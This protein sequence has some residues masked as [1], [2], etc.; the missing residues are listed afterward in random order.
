[1]NTYKLMTT[2]L[3]DETVAYDV[4]RYL[5]SRQTIPTV[6]E[7]TKIKG[8]GEATANKVLACM[9]LSA[10]YMVGTSTTTFND[11]DDIARRFCHL[12]YENQEHLCVLTLDSANHE[13][14]CHE[15]SKGLA[16]QTPFHPR[17]VLR[18]AIM[19]NAISIALCHNHPSGNIS[20]SPEDISITRVLASAC[21]IMQIVLI[22]HVIV[23][24]S[25]SYS[26]CRSEPEIFETTLNR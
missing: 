2:I 21:R 22:D 25:G 6:G 19:D 7:L 13:I 20:P 15:V 24:R 23:S 16:N 5:E 14:G 17:E 4:C 12:K 10:T 9:E 8:I 1:M 26:L 3:G 11:P 18:H